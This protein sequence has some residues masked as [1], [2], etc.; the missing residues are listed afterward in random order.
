MKVKVHLFDLNSW[1]L[2]FIEHRENRR[3]NK[4]VIVN[5]HFYLSMDVAMFCIC[6][7]NNY[8]SLGKLPRY[9]LHKFAS[10][11][12]KCIKL[13]FGFHKYSSV[14]KTFLQL[15][16]PSF[17]TVLHNARIGL[18][19]ANNLHLLHNSIVAV[20]CRLW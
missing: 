9:C 1:T 8:C 2:T 19:F 12:V 13:F 16:L 18:R 15:S 6:F 14:S 17:D 7:Y 4:L 5:R 20:S 11:Y 10:A 3:I